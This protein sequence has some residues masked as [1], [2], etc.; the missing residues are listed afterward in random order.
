MSWDL[1]PGDIYLFHAMTVHGAG[2][3]TLSNRRRRGYT[4]RYIGDD[5]V[6]DVRPGLSQPLVYDKLVPG[7]PMDSDRYPVLIGG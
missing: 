4:V 5:V 6:Y 2:G 7:Q 3:N 1:E